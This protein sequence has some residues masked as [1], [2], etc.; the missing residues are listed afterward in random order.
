MFAPKRKSFPIQIRSSLACKRGERRA[1]T[2]GLVL[3]QNL[4]RV[5]ICWIWAWNSE[6][7]W[8]RNTKKAFNKTGNLKAQIHHQ[9]KATATKKTS[10]IPRLWSS[11]RTFDAHIDD[12]VNQML[13]ST[14]AVKCFNKRTFYSGSYK[15][16]RFHVSIFPP[17]SSKW[18]W[19]CR[20]GWSPVRG[21]AESLRIKKC[22]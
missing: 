17:Q 9:H 10:Q 22:F 11:G 21:R 7:R 20:C 2:T 4:H 19:T 12:N 13:S 3:S 6:S 18:F 8:K 5:A 1:R 16:T 14:R 15:A